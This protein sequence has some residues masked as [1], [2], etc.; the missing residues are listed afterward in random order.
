M[1]EW[2]THM[3][4]YPLC[5]Q[6]D[7]LDLSNINPWP[8]SAEYV[9]HV[10]RLQELNTPCY[11]FFLS[12]LNNLYSQF[13]HEWE[14]TGINYNLC[15]LADHLSKG[16][17]I[18]PLASLKEES[19]SS[20]SRHKCNCLVEKKNDFYF[21]SE[22]CHAYFCRLGWYLASPAQSLHTTVMDLSPFPS[23]W[24]GNSP[25][26]EQSQFTITALWDCGRVY[27]LLLPLLHQGICLFNWWSLPSLKVTLVFSRVSRELEMWQ[28]IPVFPQLRA[29]A[30]SQVQT[31]TVQTPSIPDS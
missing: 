11:F 3:K 16:H 18:H 12:V 20:P 24:M 2:W 22:G 6:N 30:I 4:D 17:L 13:N 7:H 21:S 8:D 29:A 28:I 9:I 27:I 14:P 19:K 10:L 31:L 26:R 23:L 25:P 5:A 15:I 1:E